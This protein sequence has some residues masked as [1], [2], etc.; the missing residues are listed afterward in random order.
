MSQSKYYVTIKCTLG[1]KKAMLAQ[2][3]AQLEQVVEKD[4]PLTAQAP[5]ENT[6]EK[7]SQTEQVAP[8]RRGANMFGP[9]GKALATTHIWCSFKTNGYKVQFKDDKY[10]CSCPQFH[11]YCA[12][13][14]RHCM[15]I[16]GIVG[17]EV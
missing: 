16:K 8:P 17:A 4:F 11:G 14:G 13:E 10:T 12:P 3:Y 9:T 15:H 5:E 6:A 1:S 7:E 2:L